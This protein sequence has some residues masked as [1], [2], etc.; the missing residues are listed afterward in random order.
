MNYQTTFIAKCILQELENNLIYVEEN[1]NIEEIVLSK[2]SRLT[3]GEYAVI[4]IDG[5]KFSGLSKLDSLS[6]SFN[7]NSESIII[8]YKKLEEA[9]HDSIIYER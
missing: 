9:F 3:L 7:I 2:L 4:E 5:G 1:I 8:S 6:D